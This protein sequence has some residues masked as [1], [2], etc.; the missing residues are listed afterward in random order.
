LQPE[1]GVKIYIELNQSGLLTPH[2][3]T[4]E[5][6]P[7]LEQFLTREGTLRTLP[8]HLPE[9]GGMDGFFAARWKKL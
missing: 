4:P 7:D 3:I 9:V 6:R 1:E 8:C 5:E 2:P